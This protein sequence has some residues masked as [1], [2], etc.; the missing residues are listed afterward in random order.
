VLRRL[1]AP[2]LALL[3]VT[4]LEGLAWLVAMPAFQ[5]PDEG[6]HIAYVQK[7]ADAHTIPW[8]SGH[9][10]ET[11]RRLSTEADTAALWSGLGPAQGNLAAKPAWT[12]LDEALWRAR[13][14]AL[15][16]AARTDGGFA[17]SFR[18][19]PLYYLLA[20]VPWAVFG[21][22]S[23]FARIEAVKVL[24]LPLLLAIVTF[25]WLVARE[26]LGPRAGPVTLA[27]ALVALHP[28]LG[29]LAATVTPDLLLAALWCAALYVMLVVVR[30]GLTGARAAAL[31][32]LCAASALT[33]G[34]GVPLVVPAAAA[35]AYATWRARG[36]P[37]PRRWLA[38]AGVVAVGALGA[39]AV[40]VSAGA[41]N[42]RQFA[43]Y[44][45]QFYLPRLP[46]MTPTIGPPGYGVRQAF[47]DRFFGTF[48]GLEVTLPPWSLDLLAAAAVVGLAALIA[49]LVRHRAALRARWAEAGVLLLAVVALLAALHAIAYR[50]L[51]GSN[52]PVIAGRYLVPV[53]PLFGVG[54]ALVVRELPARAAAFVSAVLVSGAVLLQFAALGAVAIRFSA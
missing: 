19:P 21:G 1:P 52:D 31:V 4:A 28:Q 36:R 23:I 43:S 38:V 12:R 47:V 27:T 2:L 3:A 45:W 11:A 9:G 10:P 7:I 54:V 48:A 5:G 16:S 35:V 20:A 24:N 26:L 15:P 53:I 13:D 14:R 29:N 8:R 34:R 33:H 50:T 37:S 30:R 25:T 6:R 44:V 40:D 51:L 42:L 22:T 39:L 49:V 17:D 32:A 41:G 18:N 46:G